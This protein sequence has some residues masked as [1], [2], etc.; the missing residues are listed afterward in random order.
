MRDAKPGNDGPPAGP[1]EEVGRVDA[2]GRGRARGLPDAPDPREATDANAPSAETLR[3]RP[4]AARVLWA[5]LGF[6]S[7]ALGALGVVLPGLPT[8]PFLILAAA[9]FA[10][11]SDRLYQGLLRNRRFGPLIR[12]YRAGRGV[13]RRAKRL[14]LT[15]MAIF[16]GFALGPGMPSGWIW[17]RAVLVVVAVMGATYLLRLPTWDGPPTGEDGDGPSG[18]GSGDPG[19]GDDASNPS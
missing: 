17:P 10:R 12:Q 14:A 16:V 19:P 7:V 9:C 6:L 5:G 13:P 11:S 15:L 2:A 4:L 1:D 8:T 3:Q 18:D